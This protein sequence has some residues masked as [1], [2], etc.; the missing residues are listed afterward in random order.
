MIEGTYKLAF[1]ICL[2]VL[3]DL[4]NDYWCVMVVDGGVRLEEDGW[5]W[6]WF[7]AWD[8]PD[9][10]GQSLEGVAAVILVTYC[11]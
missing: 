5:V 3:A 4:G 2:V 10:W 1:V 11:A 7:P 9:L 6:W 8:F